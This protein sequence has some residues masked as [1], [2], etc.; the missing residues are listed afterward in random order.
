MKDF[1]R[2]YPLLSL[3]GLS[4]G[5]CTMHMGGY[6][7]GCGGGDGNQSCALARCGRDHGVEFC[8]HC[9]AYPCPN[10]D[11]LDIYDSF[12]STLNLR[13]NLKNVQANGLDACK[14]KLE[15]KIALLG[16]LLANCNAGRQKSPFA[17]AVNL[18]PLE[19]LRTIQGQL[20][21]EA[22][23]LPLKERAKAALTLL[24]SAAD[25]RGISLKLRKKTNNTKSEHTKVYEDLERVTIAQVTPSSFRD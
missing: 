3:C 19:D 16:W 6:C 25:A 11:K 18:L 8:C 12:I 1:N 2:E 22:M 5:L 14:A 9:P 10:F 13:E 4:C 17:T 7:P 15:E 20:V 23:D 24:Q 21:A